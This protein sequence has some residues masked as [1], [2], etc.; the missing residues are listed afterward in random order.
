MTQGQGTTAH[1]QTSL[2][3]REKGVPRDG[4]P[5]ISDARLFCQLHCFTG[6]TDILPIIETLKKSGFDGVL[7]QDFNDPKGIGVLTFSE[8]PDTFVEGFRKFLTSGL[9]GKLTPRP[10]LTMTGRTYS[11]GRETDLRDW[12]LV[13]PRRYAL[14]PQ[15]PWA[16]WYPLR[17]KPEFELLSREEQG[18]VLMEHSVIGRNF[19]E[20]G[21]AFDI[22][23]ACHG[24]DQHDNEFVLGLVGPELHPLSKLVQEMR[25]SQQTARYI[26]NLGPFFV[27]KACWQSAFP[28]AS[29]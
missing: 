17:R 5:Q 8:N 21:H 9:F 13:K 12:L 2:D 11:T 7:Y 29:Q 1:Q 26:Q 22:R 16:I 19:A 14:N 27:G 20:A 3:I 15:W 6:C 25:K 4:T 23:L 10:E 18:K 28:R 24:L